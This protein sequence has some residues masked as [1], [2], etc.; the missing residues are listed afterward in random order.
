MPVFNDKG[1]NDTAQQVNKPQQY[2]EPVPDFQ[3]KQGRPTKY[4]PF[5]EHAHVRKD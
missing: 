1:A 4:N 5:Q 2:T 3:E